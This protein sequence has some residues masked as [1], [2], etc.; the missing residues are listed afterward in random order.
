MT[1][2]AADHHPLV[3]IPTLDEIAQDPS[4]AASLGS[5]AAR[6]LLARC[7]VAQ[8]ALLVPAL[9]PV[10]SV[11][12]V[13]A[14]ASD[15]SDR[16]LKMPEVAKR[17]GLSLSYLYELARAGRLPVKR[18]GQGAGGKRPRGYRILESDLLE[19]EARLGKESI[20][21]DLS[22]M[23]STQRDGRRVPAPQNADRHDSGAAGGPA[24]RVFDHSQ[25]MRVISDEAR[26]G[27]RRQTGQTPEAEPKA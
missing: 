20:R 7:V 8:A 12:P 22:D 5:D 25:P 13:G 3:G 26:L 4:M 16:Y 15:G 1:Q 19:W 11:L 27:A 2:P 14:T 10:Q 23:L 9:T 24:R 21:I 6:A 17:T 18:M